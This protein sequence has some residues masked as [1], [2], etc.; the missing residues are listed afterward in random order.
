[1][2]Y[3]R[4]CLFVMIQLES[5]N[6]EAPKSAR[7]SSAVS[8]NQ[9]PSLHLGIKYLSIRQRVLRNM[10]QLSKEQEILAK[11]RQLATTMRASRAPPTG[12]RTIIGC[13]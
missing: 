3:P 7:Y 4:L 2:C 11:Q 5:S 13:Y 9:Q 6:W 10:P 1:M 12:Q 8:Y